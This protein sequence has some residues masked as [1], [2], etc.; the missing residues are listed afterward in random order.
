MTAPNP[1]RRRLQYPALIGTALLLGAVGV[2]PQSL[3]PMV[4]NLVIPPLPASFLL[5]PDLWRAVCPL[6]TAGLVANGLVA[7]RRLSAAGTQ[8][9]SVV[10]LLLLAVVVPARHV[11][12]NQHAGAFLALVGA[13][14][15]AAAAGGAVFD[16]KAG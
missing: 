6:A 8:R 12:S 9:A 5:A 10:G 4:W 3:L 11:L 14:L 2:W 15:A 7:R 13:L 1:L 16:M